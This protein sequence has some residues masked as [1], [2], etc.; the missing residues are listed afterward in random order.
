LGFRALD[1]DAVAKGP[2]D[3]C[4]A[5]RR[6]DV[7]ARFACRL[8]AEPHQIEGARKLEDGEGFG[9]CQDQRRDADGARRDMHQPADA[10]AQARRQTDIA[11]VGQRARG[12]IEDAGPR[13]QGDER[14]RRQEKQ[15][16]HQASGH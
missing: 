12:D 14:R 9:A 3:A 11:A 8:D 15:E 6:N 5:R 16:A 13:R 7:E 1:E 4:A 2:A 10:G